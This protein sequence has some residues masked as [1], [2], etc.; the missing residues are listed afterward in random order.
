MRII[1][2]AAA[3]TLLAASFS[4]ASAK[5]LKVT[6]TGDQEVPAVTTTAKGEGDIRIGANR[7]VTGKITTSGIRATM[8]HIHEA[9]APGENGPPI[10]TLEKGDDGS[11]T[12]PTGTKLT[13]EQY[14]AYKA[15]KLYVNI[16]S[17]AH[18]GGEIRA[19]LKP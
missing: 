1:L 15:G 6:L 16:H 9:A 11:W 3:A 12:V 17:E 5:D 10:I 8:A 7:T 4:V 18:K 13:D 14:A 2:P 19:P